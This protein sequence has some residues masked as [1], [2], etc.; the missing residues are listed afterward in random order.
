MSGD[1]RVRHCGQCQLNVYNLSAM[2]TKDGAELLRSAGEGRM[3][4]QFYRRLDG[5]VITDDCPTGLKKVRDQLRAAWIAIFLL[6]A[7]I[8]VGPVAAQQ[9]L[10][11]PLVTGGAI[12]NTARVIDE[13]VRRNYIAT[14][15]SSVLF[16]K[17]G[18]P[19]LNRRRWWKTYWAPA[20]FSI[21]FVVGLIVDLICQIFW[22][23]VTLLSEDPL[24][25]WFI[26]GWLFGLS[27]LLTA[28][29]FRAS[30]PM[31][32]A[33]DTDKNRPIGTRDRAR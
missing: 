24:L 21:A 14:L 22:P 32:S 33:S 20:S 1:D 2:S 7:G 12:S 17:L 4:V 15:I 16:L 9:L 10:G 11:A 25:E 19:P 18:I 30:Q 5:T 31:S 8:F 13:S 23:G 26:T 28:A 27:C 6:I 29:I 3:C